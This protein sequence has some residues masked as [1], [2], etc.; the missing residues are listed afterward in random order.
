LPIDPEPEPVARY[1]SQYAI[2]R[3]LYPATRHLMHRVTALD[4]TSAATSDVSQ[5]GP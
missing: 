2:F 3:E 1:E 5:S 4:R